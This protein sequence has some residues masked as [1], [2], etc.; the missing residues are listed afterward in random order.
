M[1]FSL[2]V[3]EGDSS[4]LPIFELKSSPTNEVFQET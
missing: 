4:A 3:Y 1:K 2:L